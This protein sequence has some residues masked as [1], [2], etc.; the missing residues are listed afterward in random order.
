MLGGAGMD[1]TTAQ[2]ANAAGVAAI[3]AAFLCG[4][5][6][7]ATA[8]AFRVSSVVCAVDCRLCCVSGVDAACGDARSIKI[9]T[10]NP[11]D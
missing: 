10:N 3:S 5:H 11:G 7:F 1:D 6:L 2:I 9:D 8:G 4:G